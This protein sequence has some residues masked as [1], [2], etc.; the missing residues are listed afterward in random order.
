LL[1]RAGSPWAARQPSGVV[2]DGRRDL[3]ELVG[4][5]AGVVGTEQQLSA[6]SQL[7]TYVRL[8]AATVASIER[9]ELWGRSDCSVHV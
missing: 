7:D 6:R 2:G 9:G 4:V 8:S 5:L 1:L 3:V